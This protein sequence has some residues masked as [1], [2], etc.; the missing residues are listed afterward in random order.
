MTA[1]P[2]RLLMILLLAA[3]AALTA[4]QTVRPSFGLL[5][6]S[7]LVGGGDSRTAVP[8]DGGV[9][10]GGDQAGL[11]LRGFADFP[12][13]GSAISVRTELF[14]NRLSSNGNSSDVR[15]NAPTALRDK[16]VGLNGAFVASTSRTAAVAPYFALG[17]GVFATTLGTNPDALSTTVTRH[18]SGMGLGLT[19]G[20]GLR[21]RLRHGPS[22]LLD[23]RYYQ[24]M[25]NTRGS[26]FMPI[27]IGA[28]F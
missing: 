26:A 6:G 1:M 21:V 13:P 7:S 10:T 23:W 9:V 4:Q 2:A 14:Y 20:M 28:S 17:A 19:A 3:P 15:V 12:I 25:Y 27:S 22:L 16:T 24:A 8:V 5:V 11:H 18:V